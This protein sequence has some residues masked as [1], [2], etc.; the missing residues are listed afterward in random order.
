[1][2]TE[3]PPRRYVKW[4]TF[5]PK[6]IL[7]LNADG[8]IEIWDW[9]GDPDRADHFESVEAAIKDGTILDDYN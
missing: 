2:T 3:S 6:E 8:S 7:Q 1:M 5:D 4:G 9:N